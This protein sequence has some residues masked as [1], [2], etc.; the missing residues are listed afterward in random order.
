MQQG[1]LVMALLLGLSVLA[2]ALTIE[3]LWFWMTT[4]RPRH[5]RLVEQMGGL[6]RGGHIDA[7]RVMAASDP[8]IYGRVVTALLDE[9]ASEAVEV[10]VVQSQRSRLERFMP[11][12]STI[13]TTAP[14]L[15]ILGTVTGIISSF[16]VLSDQSM[17]TDPRDVSQGISE[18]LLTTAAGLVVAIGVLFS[19]NV[20]RAQVDRTLSRIESLVAAVSCGRSR[21]DTPRQPVAPRA[22]G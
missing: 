3:R 19:Y 9:P 1:G 10:E 17:M 6:L 7:A 18:A 14:M 12:L 2:M 22:S 16:Q 11:T 21:V 15:G 4:N 20:F 8:T 13:I 5:L